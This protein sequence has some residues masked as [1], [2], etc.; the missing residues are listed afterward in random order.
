MLFDA[1]ESSYTIGN[2]IHASQLTSALL[3][4]IYFKE[5][6]ESESTQ[7][8]TFTKAIRY[9]NEHIEKHLTLQDISSHLK[10]SMS[11]VH[12]LFK[13][14]TKQSPIEFFIRLKIEQ[15]CR[16][17]SLTDYQVQEIAQRLG[18][19][20]VGY[21]SRTFKKIIG[22]SPRKYREGIGIEQRLP[23]T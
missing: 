14:H 10:I 6:S 4:E 21:F 15:A 16:Y 20:D 1:L 8:H 23:Y 12:T 2:F 18:Y 17:L 7:R 13:M 3:S 9:M 5:K 19:F 22:T 11:Y